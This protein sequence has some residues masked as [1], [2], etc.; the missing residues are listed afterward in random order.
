VANNEQLPLAELD[1]DEIWPYV[2]E[3]GSQPR[4]RRPTH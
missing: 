2:A 3:D 4:H 1:L